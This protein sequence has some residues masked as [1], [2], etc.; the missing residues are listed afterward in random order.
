VPGALSETKK[1]RQFSLTINTR[2]RIKIPAPEIYITGTIVA[3]ICIN[4]A[5]SAGAIALEDT[6]PAAVTHRN[7]KRAAAGL[8]RGAV[9]SKNH[10]FRDNTSIL[11]AFN[12]HPGEQLL[13]Q[14]FGA[15]GGKEPVDPN[16]HIFLS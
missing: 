1:Y 2:E 15:L 4:I 5:V 12:K 10:I 8:K 7:P 9:T 16:Q 13:Q 6:F 11:G 14:S 3:P